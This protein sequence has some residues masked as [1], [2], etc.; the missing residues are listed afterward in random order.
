MS[1]KYLT[2]A[3]ISSTAQIR[4]TKRLTSYGIPYV[5]P[6]P[7]TN[8]TIT[9]L[10]V[11]G[12]GAG[13]SGADSTGGGGAGGVL[14]GNVTANIGTLYTITLG[15]GGTGSQ[16]NGATPGSFS[17]G[18]GAAPG[19]L[20]S[21]NGANT[22]VTGTGLTTINGFGGGYGRNDIYYYAPGSPSPAGAGG[23]G[24][25]GNWSLSPSVGLA[26]GSPA[27]NLAGTQGYPGGLSGTGPG[28]N[29]QGGSG[30]GGAG[31]AGQG[32]SQPSPTIAFG[33]NGGIGVMSTITGSPIYYGGGGG[34]CIECPAANMPSFP[35]LT[36][37]VGGLGGGGSGTKGAQPRTTTVNGSAGTVNTGGGGGGNWFAPVGGDSRGFVPGTGGGWNGGS[38]T[39]IVSFPASLF[40]GNA[41]LTGANTYTISNS[42]ANV[43]IQWTASG[44]FRA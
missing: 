27:I 20:V 26:Y 32:D 34:G 21:T 18:G 23:S 1:I 17:N 12:G 11:G 28:S 44:T 40:P 39:F 6:G 5:I 24:G 8:Y 13:G 10:A 16:Y 37:G 29:F 42:G 38:G 35:N 36:A 30:G 19:S 22:T 2:T 25:G 43:V 4:D 33:G 3:N 41:N 9:Y 15:S 7:V 31:G 14:I